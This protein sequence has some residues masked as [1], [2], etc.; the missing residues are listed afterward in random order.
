MRKILAGVA[1]IL[2]LGL[3]AYAG[4]DVYAHAKAKVEK[5]KLNSEVKK[6][7]TAKET[8]Q[9]A[10]KDIDEKDV[11]ARAE[12]EKL[13]VEKGIK[14]IFLTFD[15]GPS[16]NTPKVLE[17]LKKNN[18]KATFFVIGKT[19]KHDMFKRIVDEGHAIALHT[20]SH[21]YGE[22]YSSVDAF[23]KD[24]YKLRDAIKEKTGLDPKVTRFPGG[25][26]NRKASNALKKSIIDRLTKEGYV[27]Q[28]WNCDSRDASGNKIPPQ[29]IVKSSTSCKNREINLLMHDAQAKTTTVEALQQII[30]HYKKEGYT[31]EVLT[32]DS[33]R[34]QHIA[35]PKM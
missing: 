10:L 16:D 26:S 4:K 3:I 33:P 25:S 20:Y 15:D 11:K 2:S 34:F 35:Q 27:Y 32:V 31:F 18:V 7:N 24:L 23:F 6:L 28:D 9:A 22:V 8:K 12:Y 30:D 19:G 1:F 21:E 13:K 17:I 5:A 14:T 29:T